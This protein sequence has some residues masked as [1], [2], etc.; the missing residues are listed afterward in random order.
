MERYDLYRFL[1]IFLRSDKE[2]HILIELYAAIQIE[3]GEFRPKSEQ[4]LTEHLR[5]LLE[6]FSD[7]TIT[8]LMQLFAQQLQTLSHDEFVDLVLFN[9]L[10]QI[11]DKHKSI[12]NWNNPKKR[13]PSRSSHQSTTNPRTEASILKL[14]SSA[15]E[16]QQYVA[17]QCNSSD[18]IVLQGYAGCGK[19]SVLEMIFYGE[20][21]KK[22]ETLF[23]AFNRD[24][25][26]N[27]NYNNPELESL[28]FDQLGYKLG[29][30]KS[31]WTR[32]FITTTS[33]NYPELSGILGVKAN[34]VLSGYENISGHKITRLVYSIIDQF[35]NSYSNSFSD[36]LI[37]S[38]I[39]I[40][41]ARK[42]LLEYATHLWSTM[43]ATPDFFQH[44]MIKPSFITKHWSMDGGKIPHRY[45]RLFLDEAQDVNGAFTRIIENTK[46]L[47]IITAGDRYQQLYGWRGAVNAMDKLSGDR[48]A[49]THSFRYGPSLSELSNNILSLMSSSP[50]ELITSYNPNAD[51]KIIPY[52]E[53]HPECD[54]V[55]ARSRASIFEIARTLAN[56]NTAFHLNLDIPEWAWLLESALALF[57]DQFSTNKH[58]LILPH[59]SWY[60]LESWA[61][62]AMDTDLLT[63]IKIVKKYASTLSEDLHKIQSKNVGPNYEGCVILST[64]HKI[65][66][67]DWDNVALADD[68]LNIIDKEGATTKQIDDELCIVYVALTRAKKALYIPHRLHDW[69]SDQ[70]STKRPV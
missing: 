55:L 33:I 56:E 9:K 68:F 18:L 47:Q 1:S 11:V 70:A 29:L 35:S 6:H 20:P 43:I 59:D 10:T 21:N 58:R 3:N 46:N 62:T 17:S 69:I 52:T 31:P 60:Q 12:E 41:E 23:T 27:V 37:P 63:C 57:N 45:S 4:H 44:P 7:H 61:E 65:K 26:N 36:S 2:R 66:G 48:L 42:Q 16:E 28:T 30:K 25:T 5:G 38:E 39:T 34:S 24:I 49:V 13:K 40:P 53:N 14:L 50:S 8:E 54:V 22:R 15:T 64:T 51:T 67:R 19:T 32:E